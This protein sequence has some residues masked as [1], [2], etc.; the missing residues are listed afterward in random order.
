MSN[1]LTA[2]NEQI[3]SPIIQT[4]DHNVATSDVPQMCF[5]VYCRKQIG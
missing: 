2:T 3:S 1:R 4:V 5:L